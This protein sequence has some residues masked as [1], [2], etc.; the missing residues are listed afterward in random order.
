MHVCF[1]R[2]KTTPTRKIVKVSQTISAASL[3]KLLVVAK[4]LQAN[5]WDITGTST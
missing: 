4:L 2:L 5:G 3:Q 1:Q